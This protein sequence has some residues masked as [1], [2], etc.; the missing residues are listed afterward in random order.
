MKRRM[1]LALRVFGLHAGGMVAALFLVPVYGSL[2][3]DNAVFQ[4]LMTVCII[5]VLAILLFL[6]I[7][8]QGVKDYMHDEIAQKNATGEA[9]WFAPANGLV[10]GILSQ[11]PAL[12]LLA[13]SLLLPEA[14]GGRFLWL[15]VRGWYFMFSKLMDTWPGARIWICLGGAAFTTLISALS[16]LRGRE[17][18]LRTKIIIARNDAKHERK[19]KK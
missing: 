1:K 2:W 18:R 8:D 5:A 11:V 13:G 4:W 17:L 10:A 12:V 14:A 6:P 16:Y 15:P 9:P 7:A 19:V 3:S